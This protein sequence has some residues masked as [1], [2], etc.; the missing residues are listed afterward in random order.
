M[1][2]R[3]GI[4]EDEF[5]DFYRQDADDIGDGIYYD[6]GLYGPDGG[7]DTPDTADAE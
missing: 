5:P 2:H 1:T 7:P 4:Y 6:G 3:I